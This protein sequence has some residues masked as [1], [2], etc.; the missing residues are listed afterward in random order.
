MKRAERYAAKLRGE[1]HYFTGKPCAH[2]H[3]SQRLVSNGKCCQCNNQA[4][5]DWAAT[6][7]ERRKSINKAHMKRNR[8]DKYD[9]Y[10]K[11]YRAKN[12]QRVQ[13]LQTARNAKY[14]AAKKQST[15]PWLTA[16]DFEKILVR[17]LEAA[18]MSRVSGVPHEVDHIVPLQGVDVCGLHVPWNLRVITKSFNASKQNRR[19]PHETSNQD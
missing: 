13:A 6:N 3:V 10:S 8:A 16:K 11:A 15:P 14:K 17:Y 5:L 4:A 7:A 9:A 18:C 12:R 1:L 2:G 19:Y